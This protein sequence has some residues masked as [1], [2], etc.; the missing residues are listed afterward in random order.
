LA[1]HGALVSTNDEA[2]KCAKSGDPG[3]LWI[4]AATQSGGR[5]R[6]GRVW[7]SEPGNLFASLLLI[8]PA[9]PSR[10]PEL[11]FVA[12][13]A[14]ASALRELLDGDPPLKIKWPN[15]ILYNGAKLA[16]V[17]LES[18]ALPRGFACVAGIGV[19][20][21]SH[22][23]GALYPATDLTAAAGRVIAPDIVLDALAKA[24]AH[25]LGVWSKGAGFAAIRAE[26]LAC[27]AGIGG[28][29]KVARPNETLE[30][31]FETIDATG[32]LI[33]RQE[34]GERA[35]D[36]GDVFLAAPPPRVHL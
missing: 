32:R 4:T 6:N 36:A 5:G 9:P 34:S 18:V 1:V 8:D 23:R 13:L 24:M 2:L 14:L 30:G 29:V 12:S 31:V 19:N 11:G 16:G 26:W 21:G 22:P 15:D 33:L 17:L 10:A 20:C 27:A 25:W 35:I 28:K 7:T 3:R